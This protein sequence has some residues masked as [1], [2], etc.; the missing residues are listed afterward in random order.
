MIKVEKL[1]LRG[2]CLNV[3]VEMSKHKYLG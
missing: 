2:G 3:V 1:R